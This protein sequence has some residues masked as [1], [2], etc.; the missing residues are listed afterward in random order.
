IYARY[1]EILRE[2]KV[3][4]YG[5]LIVQ[6]VQAL[7]IPVVAAAI[8]AQHQYILVDEFQDINYASGEL[9]RLIDGG[10]GRVWAVGDPWQSIYRFPGASPANLQ[11]FTAVYP[12][13]AVCD[14]QLNYRSAQ[15]ILDSSHALM[16]PDPLFSAR[17]GLKA[18]RPVSGRGPS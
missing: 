7:K 15:S 3:L 14:L 4:D 2:E 13:V 5:D 10:R 16:M 1:E 9:V 12:N 18:W 6:S 11:E 8:H 17:R